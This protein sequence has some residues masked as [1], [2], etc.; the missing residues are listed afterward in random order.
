MSRMQITLA[1]QRHETAAAVPRVFE[2][3]KQGRRQSL[4]GMGVGILWPQIA[5]VRVHMVACLRVAFS[6]GFG[7]IFGLSAVPLVGLSLQQLKLLPS[8]SSEALWPLDRSGDD[9]LVT[10]RGISAPV[11]EV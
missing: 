10:H 9:G 8:S 4:A 11:S 5:A 2:R 3:R 1:A 6:Q 7:G